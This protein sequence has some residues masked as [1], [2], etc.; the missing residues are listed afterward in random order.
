MGFYCAHH[1]A[2]TMKAQSKRLPYALK[3]SDAI[4]YSVFRQLGCAIDVRPAIDYNWYKEGEEEQNRKMWE[5]DYDKNYGED[6]YWWEAEEPS[7][8]GVGLPKLKV[9]HTMCDNGRTIKSVKF[10]AHV[11]QSSKADDFFFKKK[12]CSRNGPSMRT[13]IS[14]G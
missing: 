10:P 3:G 2:H 12:R 14:P 8:V 7:R 4:F 13:W 1:Y 11:N 6:G 5:R 9:T